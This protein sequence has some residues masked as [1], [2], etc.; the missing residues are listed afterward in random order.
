MKAWRVHEYGEYRDVL[1]FEDAPDPEPPA[2]G[3]VI[4]VAAAACNFPDLLAIAGKYQVRAPLP[5]VPGLEA[6]GKVVDRGPDCRFAIGDRVIANGLWGA[7][8]ERF[9][10]PGAMLFPAPDDMP[11]AEAAGFHITYQTSYFALVHR[12]HLQAGETLL[13]HGGAGG[14]GSSAIQLGKAFGA[15]VI[16]TAG[17]A[18]KVQTCKELGADHAI[19]YRHDD[20]V[21]RVKDITG[22]RGADVIYDPVGGEVTDKS[23]KCIAFSGRHVIIGFASGTIPSVAGNRILL[24]NIAVVGLHW[25]AYHQHEPELIHQ[26]HDALCQLYAKGV[27]PVLVHAE[28]PLSDLPTALDAVA[29]RKVRGKVVVK[30]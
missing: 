26:A 23:L 11:D 30:P 3:A 4:E 16:A 27:I 20:F 14:V 5:F 18:D 1:R 2:D 24:K 21:A 25:G 7:F 19:D 28:L 29:S 17:G 15:T 13:V 6:V 9:A 12:A 8:G 10:S 22:G